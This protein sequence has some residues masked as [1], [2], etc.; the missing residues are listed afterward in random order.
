M[1]T[2]EHQYPEGDV[3][4]QYCPFL[5]VMS[6]S[7]PDWVRC[8]GPACAGYRERSSLS[9]DNPTRAPGMAQQTITKI[10]YC[11]IAGKP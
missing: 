1:S 7:K 10:G 2:P 4:E 8:I 11:G 3:R 5:S 6:H 9:V